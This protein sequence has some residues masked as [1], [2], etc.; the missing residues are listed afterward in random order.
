MTAKLGPQQKKAS[1]LRKARIEVATL[2]LD[3]ALEELQEAAIA[4]GGSRTT[5]LAMVEATLR[6]SSAGDA[7]YRAHLELA[8]V[9]R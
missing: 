9:R 3:A 8:K 4:R 2:A 6:F 1:Q 7:L 5:P